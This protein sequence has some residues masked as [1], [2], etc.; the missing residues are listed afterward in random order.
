MAHAPLL[1]AGGAPSP[2][3]E[4]GLLQPP[5]LYRSTCVFAHSLAAP[6]VGMQRAVAEGQLQPPSWQVMPGADPSHEVLSAT[7]GFE[8][9]PESGLHVP[10]LWHWSMGVHVTGLLPEQVPLWHV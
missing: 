7:A 5:Q 1:H 3:P 9:A 10:A 2:S 8:Q 6:S 4:Q